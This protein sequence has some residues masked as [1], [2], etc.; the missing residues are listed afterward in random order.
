M[1]KAVLTRAR[2]KFGFHHVLIDVPDPRPASPALLDVVDSNGKSHAASARSSVFRHLDDDWKLHAR[3]VRVFAHPDLRAELKAEVELI[4]T[5][6]ER[7]ASEVRSKGTIK[8]DDY[9]RTW[10]ELRESFPPTARGSTA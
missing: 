10:A 4:R 6:I 5:D 8:E 3:K 2:S 1:R 7:I 9:N